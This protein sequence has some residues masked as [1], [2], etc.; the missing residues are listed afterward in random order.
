MI[1]YSYTELRYIICYPHYNEE[2]FNK[3]ITQLK[4]YGITLER[5]GNSK[6]NGIDI[7]G[8]GHNGIV[9]KGSLDDMDVVVK[10][11]RIDSKRR[12]MINEANYLSLVNKIGIGPRLFYF[13]E[14]MIIMEYVNGIKISDIT[15]SYSNLK[16]IV[17]NILEQCFML[18]RL[19]LDHGELSRMDRHAIINDK[20]VTIIDFD[21]ASQ[22]RRPRNLTSA[23]QYLIRRG[24]VYTDEIITNILKEY[25]KCRCRKCYN[26]ILSH[27]YISFTNLLNL[28]T[29]LSRVSSPA[30]SNA[31]K[32]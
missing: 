14:D 23:L 17:N 26:D 29:N 2:I 10:L 32:E 3:R 9:I 19:E 20:K 15:P 13:T 4:S 11:R 16:F 8:K 27:T 30:F 25:K 7:V 18:D 31:F 24:I 12:N 28:F 22:V 1:T 6:I 21:S 5:F